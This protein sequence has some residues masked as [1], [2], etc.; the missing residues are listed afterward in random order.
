MISIWRS[1]RTD[2]PTGFHLRS[3]SIPDESFRIS[4]QAISV[5]L[6]VLIERNK[7]VPAASLTPIMSDFPIQS[8]IL[9]ARLPVDQGNPFL[10]NWY[11]K[12]R[13]PQEPREPRSSDQAVL[14][15]EFTA[16][17][18]AK[19]PPPGFAA[20]VLAESGE[21]LS[22]R[23]ADGSWQRR[24]WGG[25]SPGRC[26]SEDEAI[27]LPPWAEEELSRWPPLFGYLLLQNAAPPYAGTLLVDAGGER[28]SYRRV[29]VSTRPSYC[30]G[31]TYFSDET[32]HHIL[33][34]MLRMD[35]KEMPWPEH[36]DVTYIQKN[37]EEFLP[38]LTRQIELEESK[39]RAT[40]KALRERGYL[41]ESEAN[42][43]R[44]KLVVTVN[45]VRSPVAG[46]VHSPPPLPK[47]V[48]TDSRTSIRYN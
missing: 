38:A 34:E 16:M 47:L 9:A 2:W 19:A 18:L 37:N 24:D 6:D 20:S 4:R 32:R 11:K 26:N 12:R 30:Y 23:V 29:S 42:T 15:A 10:E 48:A 3:I 14:Y 33:E 21:R 44:P 40:A 8:L 13:P 39:F 36:Q 35:D 25:G 7:K 5:I 45:D 31:P 27:T 17:L 28:I 22:F 1:S 43:V 46:Q 41:T